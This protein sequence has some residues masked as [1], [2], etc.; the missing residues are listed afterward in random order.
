MHEK[1]V[2]HGDLTMVKRT[3]VSMIG[4]KNLDLVLNRITSSSSLLMAISPRSYLIS[5]VPASSKQKLRVC[6]ISSNPNQFLVR[7]IGQGDFVLEC[8]L[9]TN[10]KR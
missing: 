3:F 4:K 8:D 5:V 10:L 7:Y 9:Y 6:G 1:K 2:V